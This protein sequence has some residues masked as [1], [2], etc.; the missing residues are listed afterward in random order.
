MTDP[1]SVSYPSLLACSFTRPSW[2]FLKTP[3]LFPAF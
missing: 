2:S 3:P 1:P